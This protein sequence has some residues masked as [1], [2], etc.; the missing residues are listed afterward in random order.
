MKVKCTVSH[1]T[2]LEKGRTEEQ[3]YGECK[4][5][6]EGRKQNGWRKTFWF[7]SKAD[8]RRGGSSHNGGAQVS[9]GSAICSK[10]SLRAGNGV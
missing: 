5:G 1:K 8:H 10:P 2:C 7:Y 3:V 6:R 4:G 9:G